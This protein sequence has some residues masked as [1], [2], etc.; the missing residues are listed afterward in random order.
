PLPRPGRRARLARSRQARRHRAV[1]PRRAGPR[2]HRRPGRR[3]R[4]RA[5]GRPA[6]AARRRRAGGGAGAP[7]QCGRGRPRPGTAGRAPAV[8]GMT[9]PSITRPAGGIGESPARPDGTLKVTGEFAFSSD[10]WAD[11]MLWGATL[12]SPHPR[13]RI[14]RI[15]LTGAVALPGVSAVLTAED[16][17]GRKVYG[18]EH[19]DQ[20]VLAMDEVRYQG[21]PVAIVAAD[22]PET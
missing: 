7:V 2:G 21:E 19:A 17:P 8:D 20:P 11:K 1:A 15:D 18:L 16:V 22:H 14:L 13:A 3:A 9:A 12:R 10:L 5:A 6:A 4:L